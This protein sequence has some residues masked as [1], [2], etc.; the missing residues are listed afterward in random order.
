MNVVAKKGHVMMLAERGETNV[1]LEGKM[2]EHDRQVNARLM[3][4]C[5]SN[6][7]RD[8]GGVM[9]NASASDT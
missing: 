6:S 2:S 7:Q 5:V 1:V 3:S 4:S 8:S 9:T